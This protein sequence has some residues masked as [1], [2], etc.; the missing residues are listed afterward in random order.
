MFFVCADWDDWRDHDNVFGLGLER[1]DF[2]L[3][4]SAGHRRCG[5]LERLFEYRFGNHSGWR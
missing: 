4:S 1:I 3:V 2:V 5:K